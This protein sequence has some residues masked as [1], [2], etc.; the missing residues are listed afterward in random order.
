MREERINREEISGRY[1]DDLLFANGFDDSIIG[2][3]IGVSGRAIVYDADKMATTLITRDKMEYS[4]AWEFL[5]FNTFNAYVG[6]NTPIF[7]V[8]FGEEDE[9]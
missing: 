2:V 4:E 7:V 3:S 6:D 8:K 9:I 1:G 5:E